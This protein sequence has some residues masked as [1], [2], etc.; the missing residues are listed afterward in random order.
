M[1]NPLEAALEQYDHWAR[2]RFH[3]ETA[4]P[5]GNAVAA[6]NDRSLRAFDALMGGVGGMR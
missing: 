4:T 3:V 6:Q 1:G 2:Q 5:G